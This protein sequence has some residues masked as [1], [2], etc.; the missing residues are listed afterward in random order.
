M[1]ATSTCRVYAWGPD[2]LGNMNI[3]ISNQDSNVALVTSIE[4][5]GTRREIPP[6]AVN[7]PNR[8]TKSSMMIMEPL[9]DPQKT[10]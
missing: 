10:S 9:A 2:A 1:S 8:R 7:V 3:W 4:F 5:E 6:T